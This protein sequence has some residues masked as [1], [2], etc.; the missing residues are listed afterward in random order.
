[1]LNPDPTPQDIPLLIRLTT[2][3]D[4]QSPSPAEMPS[5]TSLSI[6]ASASAALP[7]KPAGDPVKSSDTTTDPAL[8]KNTC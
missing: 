4:I 1:M 8:L 5:M 7:N 6:N 3:R 2:G